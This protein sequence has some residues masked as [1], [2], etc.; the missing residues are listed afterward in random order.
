MML[1]Y[2]PSVLLP[3]IFSGGIHEFTIKNN[4]LLGKESCATCVTVRSGVYHAFMGVCYP[5]VLSILSCLPVAR[6][7]YTLSFPSTHKGLGYMQFLKHVSPSGSVLLSLGLLNMLI[8]MGIARKEM[9]AFVNH[10]SKPP[11]ESSFD[12]EELNVSEHWSE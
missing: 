5:Y 3:S 10:L 8:G 9:L 6:Q 7:F 11:Q 2:A 12:Q 1:T 4:I